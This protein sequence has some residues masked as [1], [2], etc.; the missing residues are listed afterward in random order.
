MKTYLL[1]IVTLLLF[2]IGFAASLDTE[3][4]INDNDIPVSC[5]SVTVKK[6]FE[7]RDRN[8]LRAGDTYFHKWFWISGYLDTLDDEGTFFYIADCDPT[9]ILSLFPNNIKCVIPSNKRTEVTDVLKKLEKG[10]RIIIKG[11]VSEPELLSTGYLV[12]VVEVF[13]N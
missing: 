5:E 13:A 3:E 12:T 4:T 9:S 7:D 8:E 10:D 6:M 11:R 1:S 2:V